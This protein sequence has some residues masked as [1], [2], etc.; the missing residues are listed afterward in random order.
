M[1]KSI[2]SLDSREQLSAFDKAEKKRYQKL[3]KAP[4]S[5]DKKYSDLNLNGT[6]M[7]EILGF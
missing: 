6:T 1:K 7:K 3:A 5:S 4:E 2:E